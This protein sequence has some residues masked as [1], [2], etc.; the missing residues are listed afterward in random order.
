ME[1]SMV[2]GDTTSILK[3]RTIDSIDSLAPKASSRLERLRKDTCHM[4][5]S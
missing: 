4:Y 3:R 5:D 1:T 2:F